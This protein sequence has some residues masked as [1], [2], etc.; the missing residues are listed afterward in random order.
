MPA[1]SGCGLAMKPCQGRPLCQTWLLLLQGCAHLMSGSW[2]LEQR[3]GSISAM[4]RTTSSGIL[5][6]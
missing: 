1:A 4:Q 3:L 2:N 5:V 6:D